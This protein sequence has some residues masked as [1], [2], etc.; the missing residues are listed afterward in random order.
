MNTQRIRSR[1]VLWLLML[2]LALSPA[3][4]RAEETVTAT[5][6]VEYG[7]SAARTILGMINALRTGPD[8]W[9]W[10]EDDAT[11][12]V[13]SGLDELSYSA[14]LERVAMQ[15]A[16]ELVVYYAHTR[17]SGENTWSAYTEGGIPRS[18]WGENIAIGFRSASSV[19][20]AW[21]EADKKYDGQGHRRNML[22]ENFHYV[23][24]GHA[25][26]N[27]V[28]CWVEEFSGDAPDGAGSALD[29]SKTVS[30]RIDL[31][32]VTVESVGGSLDA[33]AL[34]TNQSA[35]LPALSL[36][37]RN[38]GYS[39]GKISLTAVPAWASQDP[40]V[41]RIDNGRVVGI[42]GGSTA[43]VTAAGGQTFTLPVQVKGNLLVLAADGRY[44]YQVNGQT[45][46]SKNGL[47]DC[48]GRWAYLTAGVLQPFTG[49]K[50]FDGAWYYLHEGIWQQGA[51]GFLDYGG[52]RFLLSGG[53]VALGANGLVNDPQDPAAWYFCAN[54]QVQTQYSGL[55]SY[56]GASF[57]VKNGRMDTAVNGFITYDGGIFFVALGRIATE[58][59][60][61]V[62]D[63]MNPALWYFCAN[64]QVQTNHTGLALYDGAWF[65]LRGGR[66]AADFSGQ[67]TYDG[68]VFTVQNGML[69]N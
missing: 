2:A 13:L 36:T 22:E 37:L 23:G 61:L 32:L 30:M 38:K 57:Y 10:N 28:H 27:G 17:P 52:G 68:G 14:A 40:A 31:N 3:A 44:H 41:A 50:Q 34:E 51:N 8:A 59:N 35:A 15:R 53:K 12:T 47:V 11:Q 62:Q 69:V 1:A 46:T 29:G 65:Y 24:I 39:V 67:I 19:N 56:N 6:T 49:L 48:G 25:V 7:Q 9:Y 64:G 26:Y 16:A 55:A 58:A 20:S 4:A 66:L 54:G 45:D 63:I 43:L 21:T 5:L 33:I 60:G 42:T 18:W